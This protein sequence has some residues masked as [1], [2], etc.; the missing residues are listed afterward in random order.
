MTQLINE[1]QQWSWSRFLFTPNVWTKRNSYYLLFFL[2]PSFPFFFFFFL[3]LFIYLCYLPLL[4]SRKQQA[5]SE[6]NKRINE[7]QTKFTTNVSYCEIYGRWP[8]G[9]R[10]IEDRFIEDTRF[11]QDLR[12]VLMPCLPCAQCRHHSSLLAPLR[13]VSLCLKSMCVQTWSRLSVWVNYGSRA[14]FAVCI[15]ARTVS[16]TRLVAFSFPHQLNKL[17]L[18]KKETV[19]VSSSIV[20]KK[21]QRGSVSAEFKA[22]G[23]V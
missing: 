14:V 1:Q 12:F 9:L 23:Q 18:I 13:Q 4:T 7:E 3:I 5:T 16:H 2:C 6:T 10:F 11:F 20:L 22:G 8:F 19:K 15:F 21:S 17:H